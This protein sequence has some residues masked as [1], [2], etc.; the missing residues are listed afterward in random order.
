MIKKN[1]LENLNNS[2]KP[3][4]IYR[5][6]KGFDLYTDFSKKIILTKNNIEKFIN[7]STKLKSKNKE[8]IWG[9]KPNDQ[10]FKDK[11]YKSTKAYVLG[12]LSAGEAIDMYNN[13]FAKSDDPADLISDTPNWREFEKKDQVPWNPIFNAQQG[14]QNVIIDSLVDKITNETN[15]LDSFLK[16]DT[17]EDLP[18]PPPAE[19]NEGATFYN[20]LRKDPVGLYEEYT[21]VIPNY[22]KE[23]NEI[24]I[25]S[26]DIEGAEEGEHKVYKMNKEK[27]RNKFY[28]QLLDFSKRNKGTSAAKDVYQKQ[29]EDALRAGTNAR[30]SSG[31]K[32]LKF[33]PITGK[34][35]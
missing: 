31:N 18:P 16:T 14:V 30:G 35:E 6:N 23:K 19:V 32:V 7:Q 2:K 13:M 11:I 9:L 25:Y 26:R 17:V 24:T 28:L 27:D 20:E 1:Y 21:G 33:N 29:F 12:G 22:N 34:N 8:T 5:S 15:G 3:F 4:I 10:V